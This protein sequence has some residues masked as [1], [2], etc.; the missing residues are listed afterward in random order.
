MSS[1]ITVQTSSTG[2]TLT[3]PSVNVRPINV[4]TATTTTTSTSQTLRPI[5]TSNQ[6]TINQAID[7]TTINYNTI[8]S[9]GKT[10]RQ[11][12]SRWIHHGSFHSRS[13]IVPHEIP[14]YL[15]QPNSS[16]ITLSNPMN[17]SDY[18]QIMLNLP[19]PQIKLVLQ[20]VEQAIDM[21]MKL[22]Y[23]PVVVNP[24]HA[25]N[26]NNGNDAI[27]VNNDTINDENAGDQG[28]SSGYETFDEEE[29]RYTEEEDQFLLDCLGDLK[30]DLLK[31]IKLRNKSS[32]LYKLKKFWSHKE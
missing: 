20:E 31:M 2:V 10:I 18:Y 5:E 23:F 27:S 1:P 24:T 15:S 3:L 29:E 21:R 13:N 16:E 7:E 32:R 22:G 11:K 8:N 26:N 25:N 30:A 12:F 9:F 14:D 6:S 4:N 19:L 28:N 17:N